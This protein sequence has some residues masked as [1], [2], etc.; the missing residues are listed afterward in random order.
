MFWI[1]LHVLVFPLE[2][3]P[4]IDAAPALYYVLVGNS[5]TITAPVNSSTTLVN[6]SWQFNDQVLQDGDD[7][8][9]NVAGNSTSFVV[10]LTI[11]NASLN[12]TGSYNLSVTNDN[13]TSIATFE[14]IVSG[15]VLDRECCSSA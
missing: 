7:Y 13:G 11:F 10:T 4:T 2:E 9:I 6:V 14:L 1:N 15:E 5:I 12:D 3:A 8:S